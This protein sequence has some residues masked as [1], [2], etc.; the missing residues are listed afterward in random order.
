MFLRTLE[1]CDFSRGRFK[2]EK[3][4]I[5][6]RR[7]QEDDKYSLVKWLS[8]PVVLDFY[9]GRDNSF[10][11][12]KVN[13]NFYAQNPDIIRCIVEF[14]GLNIGY[15]QFYLVNDKTSKITDYHQDEII[16]GMDQFIGE[17][18]CWNKGIGTLHVKTMTDYTSVDYPKLDRFIP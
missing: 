5:K 15:I 18:Q 7:L 10:D 16:F 12:K 13:K 17:T 3:E 11:M 9:E 6:V 1:S 14:E 2:F 4:S 8:D